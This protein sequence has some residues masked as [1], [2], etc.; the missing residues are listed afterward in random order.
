MIRFW[1]GRRGRKGD[2]RI[3]PSH[4]TGNDSEKTDT[5]SSGGGR[6]RGPARKRSEQVW[7][8]L[9]GS[10][11][12]TGSDLFAVRRWERFGSKCLLWLPLS[13]TPS[14]PTFQAMLSWDRSRCRGSSPLPAP[15]DDVQGKPT[16]RGGRCV[17]EL[18]GGALP[19]SR[20]EANAPVGCPLSE[21]M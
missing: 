6:A 7:R 8:R 12:S 18:A 19:S 10:W 1:L 20:Y 13:P 2:N 3:L 4:A 14:R 16:C 21:Q 15:M 17:G 9:I 5:H 11:P